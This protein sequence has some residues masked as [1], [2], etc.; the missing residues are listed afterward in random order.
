MNRLVKN[1][2]GYSDIRDLTMRQRRGRSLGRAGYIV[3]AFPLKLRLRI[4]RART[5]TIATHAGI[6]RLVTRSSPRTSLLR[7]SKIEGNSAPRVSRRLS[8]SDNLKKESPYLMQKPLQKGNRQFQNYLLPLRQN[9]RN[10]SMCSLYRFIFLHIKLIF[11]KVLHG[12]ILKRRHKVTL[13]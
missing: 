4:L 7:S 2:T 11:M 13:K 9:M 12:L 5:W 10:H 8:E 1:G 3:L 6:L